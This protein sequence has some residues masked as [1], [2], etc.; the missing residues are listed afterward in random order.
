MLAPTGGRE[1]GDGPGRRPA[2]AGGSSAAS[3]ADDYPHELSGGQKQRVM[4]AMA[5]ACSPSLVIADEPTTALDVMVQAQ[6]LNLLTSSSGSSAWRCSSSRTTCR[7]SSR[8]ATGSRSCTRARSSRRDPPSAVFRARPSVHR[9]RSAASF[10][11]SATHGSEGHPPVSGE[12]H[13][14][15]QHIPE[16]A[17]STPDAP[18]PSNHARTSFPRC[19]R[20]RRAGVRPACSSRALW[21]RPGAMREHERAPDLVPGRLHVPTGPGG[22]RP[23]RDFA[24]RVGLCAG[25]GGQE[26]NRGPRGRRRRPARSIGA[27]CSRWRASRVAARPRPHGRSWV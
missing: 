1:G 4:I 17:P 2:G 15:P 11:R 18:R 27:K 21:L 23:R 10:P 6:V 9:S 5:L 26:G 25:I 22:P 16:G 13:R 24:G 20:R 8:S 14:D 7:S 12:T 3:P 19:S